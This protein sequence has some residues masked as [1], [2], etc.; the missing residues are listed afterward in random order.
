MI[1]LIHIGYSRKAR[2]IDGSFKLHVEDAYLEDLHKARALFISIDGS[3][4]PFIIESIDDQRSLVVKVEDINDP[5]QAQRLLGTEIYLHTDEVSEKVALD[6]QHPLTGY[7][8]IDQHDTEIGIIEEMIEYPD[9]LLA[10]I[11]ISNKEILLPIHE[12]LILAHNEEMQHIHLT[13]ADGLLT[14]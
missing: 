14:L 4:V 12:D 1:D 2:G 13:L 7:T 9:Q 3:E 11:I 8:V 5:E 6:S 10:K